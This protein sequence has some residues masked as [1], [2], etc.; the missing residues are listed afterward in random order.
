MKKELSSS[1]FGAREMEVIRLVTRGKTNP[2][3]ARAL[4]IARSTVATHLRNI[5]EKSGVSNRTDLTRLVVS[6]G[7]ISLD[8]TGQ[9]PSVI[10]QVFELLLML[11]DHEL[12]WIMGCFNFATG[13]EP[14]R[15]KEKILELLEKF[16]VDRQKGEVEI[17]G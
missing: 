2:E 17:N 5:M 13:L 3:I 14:E 15:V 7:L 12:M 16:K 6:Q 4:H 11:P 8:E 10:K 9:Q 1:R